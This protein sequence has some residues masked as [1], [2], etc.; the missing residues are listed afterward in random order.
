M[1]LYFVLL[2]SVA[3]FSQGA[4]AESTT[5]YRIQI[6]ES[7]EMSAMPTFGIQTW[8]YK[9]LSSPGGSKF[10]YNAD[11]ASVRAEL[12]ALVDSDGMVTHGSLTKGRLTTHKV[13]GS[14][15]N[16]LPVPLTEPIN[17]QPLKPQD[18]GIELEQQ[19]SEIETVVEK[20]KTSRAE[21]EA[22]LVQEGTFEASVPSQN[23]PWRGFWWSY[24][25]NALAGTTNSPLAKYDRYVY[26]RTGVT[27]RVASWERTYHKFKGVAWEGHCNGWAA[28][29]VLRAEPNVT[30]YHPQSGIRFTIADQKGILAEEDYCATV[31]FYGRRNYGK[32]SN[33]P[34]DIY[35][36]E[37][38]KVITYYIGQ[39]GKVVALDYMSSRSVDNHLISGYKMDIVRRSADTF[40]VTTK[41]TVHKY[42]ASSSKPPG[43]APTYIRTYKYNLR[44][45]ASG[46]PIAGSWLTPNPDFLWVPLSPV[47]CSSNNPRMQQQFTTEIL[48]LPIVR[49]TNM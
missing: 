1:K 10:I 4:N 46:T 5:C 19:S 45:D 20:L 31:A 37:F 23:L 18:L 33:D 48:N 28:S 11:Q 7:V 6:Q 38:H 16:P 40:T 2:L 49:T 17:L 21:V 12:S 25:S 35:P 41:L 34:R 44:L 39:L 29:A 14:D 24:K 30:R 26:S 36:A 3:G 43:I 15:V 27:P 32:A 22:M 9:N 8:C 13:Y 42:D 47:D